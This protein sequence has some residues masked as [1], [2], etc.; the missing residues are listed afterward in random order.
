M[1]GVIGFSTKES[2]F[3]RTTSNNSV[4][5]S[6]QFGKSYVSVIT[7][8][9]TRIS[10]KIT[11]QCSLIYIYCKTKTDLLMDALCSVS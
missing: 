11:Q 4:N 3:S 5:P 2:H 9:W 8:K 6:A 7:V 10:Y 1:I